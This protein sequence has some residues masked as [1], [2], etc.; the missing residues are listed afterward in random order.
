MSTNRPAPRVIRFGSFE[1]DLEACELRKSGLRLK[2]A[3][4]PFQVLAILL[5]NPRE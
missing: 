4:Q 5:E 2:F 1:L 3:G